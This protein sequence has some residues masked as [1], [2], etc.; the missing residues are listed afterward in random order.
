MNFEEFKKIIL[1]NVKKNF[2][3]AEVETY[4]ILKCNGVKLSALVV[5]MDGSNISPT[6]YL[7]YFY[8]ELTNG[9][10]LDHIIQEIISVFD[11]NKKDPMLLNV[12][13]FFDYEKAKTKVTYKLINYERNIEL[14][15]DVPHI[16]FLDLAIIFQYVVSMEQKQ[17]ATILIHNKHLKM[18]EKTTDEL[19]QIAGNN[20]KRIFGVKCASMQEVLDN[21]FGL[22]EEIEDVLDMYI[23]TNEIGVSGASTMLYT[24]ELK[25]ISERLKCNL[26]ILPSS[27]HEVIL[28][29]AGKT[30]N[31]TILKHMVYQVNRTQLIT[32]EILSDSVYFFSCEKNAIMLK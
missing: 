24:D 29:P 16:R 17:S 12:S 15:G 28:I 4:P 1:E 8:E 32:E 3:N 25:K 31:P 10:S 9:T 19:F 5:H 30:I 7:E 26:Y 20:T 11:E 6:I 14:L 2:F 23:L 27:V 18:W 21:I 22:E 13:D